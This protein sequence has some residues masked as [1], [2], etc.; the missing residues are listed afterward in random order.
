MGIYLSIDY[1]SRVYFCYYLLYTDSI[2][3]ANLERY[4][5]RD[6]WSDSNNVG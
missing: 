1:W 2:D 3:E 5:G 4:L 6:V